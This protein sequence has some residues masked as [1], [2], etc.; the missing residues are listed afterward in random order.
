VACASDASNPDASATLRIGSHVGLA[1]MEST[2]SETM[3]ANLM[4]L[5]Y[6]TLSEYFDRV[7]VSG[8]TVRLH[9]KPGT[10]LGEQQ[11]A[12]LIEHPSLEERSVE[13]GFVILRLKSPAAAAA[14]ALDSTLLAIGAYHAVDSPPDTMLLERRVATDGPPQIQVVSVPS[15]EEEWRR[16]I[17]GG[18]DLLPYVQPN[19]VRYLSQVPSVRIVP[20]STHQVASLWFHV[21]RGPVK[22]VRIRR[23]ISL[24]VRRRALADS[25]TRD[26]RD[27]SPGMEAVDAAQALLQ[28]LDISVDHPLYMRLLVYA[29][30]P[31]FVR[32]ALVL[33]QQLAVVGVELQVEA[34]E[35]E[36]FK[37]RLAEH[38]FDTL[39]FG[40]DTTPHYWI[41]LWRGSPGNFTGY[42]SDDFEAARNAG[43]EVAGRT[44]LERDVPLTPL[45]VVKDAVAVHD[46]FCGVHPAVSNEYTWLAHVH[47]CKPGEEN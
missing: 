44:V 27:A 32:A 6:G 12:L 19:A 45:F 23:A 43:D 7:D 13:P 20:F 40:G 16:F 15:E 26:P 34:V 3:T 21:E 29:G 28:E 1:P 38:D 42:D 9:V 33:Q 17:A 11:L 22:D 4:E 37:Q 2:V 39:L 41:Y 25:V 8:S 35:I 36:V 5:V 10:S 47:L 31:D 14:V 18:L 24:A 30:Q 46:R